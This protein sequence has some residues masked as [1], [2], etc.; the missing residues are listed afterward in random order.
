MNAWLV[1]S[2]IVVIVLVGIVVP[3]AVFALRDWRR[4]WRLTC[5]QAGAVAQI[6]V[7]PG[8]AALAELLGRQPEIARCSLWPAL[9]ACR[10]DCLALPAAA[11]QRMRAG[12]APPRDRADAAVRMIV[13]PL[14][15][16][17]GGEAV[18]PAVGELARAC[19]ATV[20]LLRVVPPV[21]VV[22][23]EHDRVVAYADQEMASVEGAARDYLNQAA[24]ALAGVAVEAAVRIGDVDGQVIEEAETA[25]ADLIAMA[26]H[27]RH[28]VLSRDTMATR[29]GQATTIPLLLLPYDEP[30]AA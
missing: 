27:R 3:I 18:L 26:A 7:A 29:L 23:G 21:G 9:L 19:G 14:D 1:L 24:T 5:P 28:G 4:P 20:R 15:G 17:R 13:V 10:Q 2:G 11:R 6:T 8:E 22:C 30:A 25:G 12:E 16:T